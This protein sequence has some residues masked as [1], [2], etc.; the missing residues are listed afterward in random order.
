[1]WLGADLHELVRVAGT[2][3]ALS[4]EACGCKA[5]RAKAQGLL[6]Q[7]RGQN[8]PPLS[9]SPAPLHNFQPT[10]DTLRLPVHV[11]ATEPERQGA[12]GPASSSRQGPFNAERGRDRGT[13]NTANKERPQPSAD[14]FPPLWGSR[15]SR[16]QGCEALVPG[17]P[18]AHSCAPER[19]VA[20]SRGPVPSKSAQHPPLQGRRIG[21]RP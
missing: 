17:T 14:T 5:R 8:T 13:A 20:A 4:W 11:R 9:G 10:A 16:A 1:M 2:R 18:Q 6:T 3:G 7:H 21:S 15:G 12:G 19:T